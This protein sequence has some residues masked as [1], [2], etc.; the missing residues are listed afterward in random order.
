MGWSN[1]IVGSRVLNNVVKAYFNVVNSFKN[2]VEPNPPTNILT[3]ETILTQYIIKQ[4]LKVFGNKFEAA[5]QNYLQQFRDC[6]LVE[7]NKP[8]DLSY[9][10]QRKILSYLIFL[11]ISND[12]AEIKG[13]GCVDGRKQQNCLSKEDT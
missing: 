6:R 10:Q 8:Q 2:F 11:K 9:E 5:V 7:P 4:G 13:R 3:N 1:L 12:K